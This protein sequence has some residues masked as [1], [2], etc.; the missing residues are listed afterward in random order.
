[1]LR[2]QVCCRESE[3]FDA[4]GG[5]DHPSDVSTLRPALLAR[6]LGTAH[7]RTVHT[8]YTGQRQGMRTDGVG[9]WGTSTAENPTGKDQRITFSNPQGLTIV[10]TLRDTGSKVL[11][12]CCIHQFV[13]RLQFQL[14]SCTA[15]A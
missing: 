11:N 15:I 13:H 3:C 12:G 4:L 2:T 9:N 5:A 8:G 1:M 10:G 6:P 14:L 7:P